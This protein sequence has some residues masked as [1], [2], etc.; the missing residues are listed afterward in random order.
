VFLDLDQFNLISDSFG[1]AVDDMMREISK[2]LGRCLREADA[3]MQGSFRT[4]P[5]EPAVDPDTHPVVGAHRSA[6]RA[7]VPVVLK[8][9][10]VADAVRRSRV[11][12]GEELS[13]NVTF[14]NGIMVTVQPSSVRTL[15]PLL[16]E[17]AQ[18]PC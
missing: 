9:G 8:S 1:H 4:A 11:A 13:V 5:G 18:S 7:L 10:G 16:S 3:L 17:L 14:P 2:R 6:A 15:F 12:S